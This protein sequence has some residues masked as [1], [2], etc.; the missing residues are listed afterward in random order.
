MI[1]DSAPLVAVTDSAII[2]TQTDGTVFVVRAFK[3]SK[4]LSAQGLRALRDVDAR[5]VGVVLNAVN[6]NRQEYSVLLSLL[7][8]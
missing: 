6:L 8:L 1:I 4:H 7:L 2:S 5:I 3:T